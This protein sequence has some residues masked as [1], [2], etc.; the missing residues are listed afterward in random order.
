MRAWKIQPPEMHCTFSQS[1]A[2]QAAPCL[3]VIPATP[4]LV[5]DR[6]FE[7]IVPSRHAGET[8]NAVGM[9]Q[10]SQP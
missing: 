2:F 4:Y 1:T 10:G 8:R 9:R 6:L 3:P 5:T 7:A